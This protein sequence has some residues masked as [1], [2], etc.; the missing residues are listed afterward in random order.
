M[1]K[2]NM[3]KKENELLGRELYR[4][5]QELHNLQASLETEITDYETFDDSFDDK[6]RSS[7]CEECSSCMQCSIVI[8]FVVALVIALV[9]V[10]PLRLLFTN[11]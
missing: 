6:R 11:N 3:L 10:L 7:C 4:K 2:E 8:I 1:T 5:S 9:F